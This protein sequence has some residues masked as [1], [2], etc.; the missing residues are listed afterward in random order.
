MNKYAQAAI[1]A[2]RLCINSSSSSP[3]VAWDII[4]TR[5]FGARSASQKK[6][7]PRDAFLGLCE[8]G[9]IKGISPG[10]YCNSIKNKQYALLALSHLQKNPNLSKQP[11]LL[12]KLVLKG[13]G[14]VHNSQ[15]DV[16]TSLWNA[17]LL[18]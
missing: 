13:E 16:V 15:M 7:C 4:T 1:E 5:I 3:R 17:G 18:I 11:E 8:E 9:H 12:W 2:T 6:G 10:N 14:K